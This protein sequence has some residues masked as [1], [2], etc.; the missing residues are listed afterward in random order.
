[1][2]N[3]AAI[4]DAINKL[5]GQDFN[6]RKLT[7]SKAQPRRER[8]SGGGGGYSSRFSRDSYGGGRDRQ[9]RY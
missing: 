5:N 4:E 3:E 2:E 7:V 8:S 9:S 6:G 1:V